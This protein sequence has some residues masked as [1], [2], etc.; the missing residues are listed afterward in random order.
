MVFKNCVFKY[1]GILE[2]ISRSNLLLD[3]IYM[4][5]NK[6]ILKK[7]ILSNKNKIRC[8]NVSYLILLCILLFLIYIDTKTVVVTCFY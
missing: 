7:I 5:K 3:I 6:I 2:Y 8:P 1:D 4:M